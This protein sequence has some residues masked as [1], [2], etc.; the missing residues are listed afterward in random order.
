MKY[1][2]L[3]IVFLGTAVPASCQSVVGSWKGLID[4]GA[5]KIAFIMHLSQNDE[6][7]T[8]SFDSPDQK[9]FGLKGSETIVKEDSVKAKI[10]I[11]RGSY[12]GKWNGNDLIEGL[13]SQGNFKTSLVLKRIADSTLPKK[14]VPKIRSQ[15]PIAPFLYKSEDVTYNNADN[16][17]QFGATLT[18]P[19]D[20][21]DFPTV[22]IISG[23]GPQD[24]NGTMFEHKPYLVLADYLTK[25]GIAV[26]RVDDRGAGLTNLGNNPL[27]L[28]SADFAKDVESSIQYLSTRKEINQ[29]KIGLI[30]H[31]EGGMIAPMVAV[32]NKKIAFIVL[33]AA[34][35][36]NGDEILKFQMRRNFI[37]KN[38]LPEDEKRAANFVNLMINAFKL[39]TNIDSIKNY[40]HVTYNNW[41]LYYTDDE[42]RKIFNTIGIKAYLNLADQFGNELVWLHYFMNYN[43][44]YNL[45]ALKIPILAMNG[46]SDIQV[47]V[48]TNLECINAALKKGKNKKF[49][50]RSFPD[51]NHLFQTCKKDTDPYDGID[52]TFSPI[53]LKY[54]SDWINT[55]I[56]Q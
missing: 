19:N 20:V 11:I 42:E 41:K 34:P 35:G 12:I 22:I 44:S 39:Y 21:T 31:S 56:Q 32:N 5:K 29:K 16:S 17:V 15:T 40:M 2:V 53:A 26:L 30:G 3:F 49:T 48:R 51:L 23:S 36:V 43:P 14:R 1:I 9:A 4:I 27:Q 55:T 38:L 7:Y 25:N 33:L 46:E 10:P 24:R 6:S 8:S 13:F 37:K 54:I 47:E 18:L 45:S 28:T 52:E 50:I